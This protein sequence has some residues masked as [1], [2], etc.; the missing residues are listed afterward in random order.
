MDEIEAR[1]KEPPENSSSS[2]LGGQC[3]CAI[4]SKFYILCFRCDSINHPDNDM[5]KTARS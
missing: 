4:I 3:H 2:Q 1:V 5:L